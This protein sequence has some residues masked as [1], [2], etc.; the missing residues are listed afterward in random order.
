MGPPLPLLLLLLPLL[1]PHALPAAPASVPR[2]RQLPGRLGCLL[3]DG[4][5]GA[6]EACVNDGVFGRCQK[7]PAMDFYRYEVSPVALHRLRVALQ[8]LSSTG[9]TWQDDYTQ[10]VMAQEL[11][12]LPKTYLR[13]PA[14]SSAAGPSKQ[15]IGSERRYS[16]EGSAALAKAL[17]RHLPFLE[18]LSQAPASDVL[19]RTQT[20]LDRPPAEGDDPFSESL[21]TYMAHT[22]AL[23]YPPGPQAQLPEDLLPRT[24]SQLQPDELSPKVDRHHLMAALG[25]YAAR[26]PPAPPGEGGSEPQYLL[27]APPRMSRPLLAP[28]TPQ[29]WS[30]PLGDPNDSPSTGEG[31][32]IQTLLKDLRRQPA[33]AGDL[34]AL[35]LDGMAE[36]MAGLMQGGDHRGPGGGPGRM[37][38]GESGEQT[39][40]PKAALHGDSFPDDRVQDDDR[41]YQEVHRLSATLGDLLQEHESQLSPGALPFAKPLKMERKE[42]EHP[43]ASLSSEEETAGVENVKSLTYF[44]DLL[45]LQPHLQP[46]AGRF[47]ELQSLVPEPSKEEQ[48]L[49]AGAREV[50]G[51]GLQ[52]EVKPSEEEAW[53][54]IVTDR[55]VLGPAVTFK[56]S[57]NV[58]NVT[59]ADVQKA[60]V[61]NKD[62]LEETSGLKILQTGVGSKSKFKFLPP[63]AEQ[64]DSTKFIALTLVSLACILGVLLASGLIYCLRHRSQHRLK[65]KLSG[66]GGDLGADATSAYQELCRQR[67]AT[68]PPDRPEG[69]H[70]S[71]IS[72][73]SSQFSDG[74]MPSPSARSSTSSWSE[75]PVQSNMD[76]TTG[77]MILSYM[78]DHLKNK[79]RLEKEEALCAYQAEPNSS[80][81]AQREE[82]MPKN[83]SLAVLTYDHSRVL[84]KAEN[85]HSH[86]DYINASPIMDHDPRNPVYIATQGPLPATVADFWQMVWESGCVV[87]VMLTPLSENGVRQCYHY[88]PD[89]GSNLYHIYEVN[90]VSEHIWC[91]DFLVRSFYL[92]NLG[93]GETR[94]VTQFH[95]LSWYDRGV[96]SSARSLLDFRRK[97]NKCYRGR[98]CPVIVHCEQFEFA[99]TAVAEEVNAILKALPQ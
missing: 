75:E 8:K 87:I 59:T 16:R 3:E 7:V 26:R 30:S 46:G 25:A 6:S 11:A 34:S 65:E 15:S 97:V 38:L 61:D 41:L 72:S 4:L 39:D 51:D 40:G 66:L 14:V 20:V 24:L 82:N 95:F 49:P 99:L 80:L 78:E 79:N 77:H 76:I 43:E 64:E 28:A 94:T 5:C 45:G 69:P 73:V 47:A 27:H 31:A 96:P 62:K 50:L 42:S 33:E 21:L 36:L 18:A 58:Q 55:E 13:R 10:Y 60:T 93:T 63:Q 17:Q 32:R 52:L 35:E 85:S 70:T 68:R 37:A 23:T 71:R 48:S 89:E 2:G 74:P 19:T 91:E 57:A 22:S 1:P 81:V 88:W 92:K 54:Y 12:N 83:R 53:G 84:L 29:K 67:M 9:F 90:L 44:K 86:S 56:V 98:S